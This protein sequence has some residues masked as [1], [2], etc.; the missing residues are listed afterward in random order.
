MDRQEGDSR[1][2]N[3]MHFTHLDNTRR[4]LFCEPSETYIDVIDVLGRLVSNVVG[5][6][7]SANIY[8]RGKNRKAFYKRL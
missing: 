1:Y 4:R 5:E 3:A 2:L 8:T 6:R 7:T